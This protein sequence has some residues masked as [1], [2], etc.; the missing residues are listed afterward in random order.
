V[1]FGLSG[2]LICGR[3]LAENRNTG[4][5]SLRDF[6]IRRVFRIIP[7]ASVY[8]FCIV[9]FTSIGLAAV[10]RVEL[11]GS[12]F[13]LRNYLM[14]TQPWGWVTAHFWSLAVEEHFYLLWPGA[15]VCLGSRRARRWIIPVAIAIALWR[16]G[17]ERYWYKPFVPSNFYYRSDIRLDAP[18]WGCWMALLLE[19]KVWRSRL[20]RW[21]ESSC[22]LPLVGL[23]IFVLVVFPTIFSTLITALIPGMLVCT[24][25]HPTNAVGRLLELAPI[26]W[27][28]RV[29]YSIYIWQQFFLLPPT[30]HALAPLGIFQRLPLNLLATLVVASA[31]YY[32]IERPLIK[33]GRQV[34]NRKF[35]NQPIAPPKPRVVASS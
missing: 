35:G 27:V 34:A 26:R 18:L 24:L 7:P 10:P 6:Y 15:L 12:L 5:I 30:L 23:S 3:L 13:F 31:S 19:S 8:I 9:L 2:L 22:A 20:E 25:L 14:S 4:G 16:L 29:S 33:L 17:L 32:F 11:F 21:T 28:G 1:F